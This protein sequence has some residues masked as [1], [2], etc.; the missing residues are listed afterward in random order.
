VSYW[1]PPGLMA[2]DP[3][4]RE[5]DW[6]IV[7]GRGIVPGDEDAWLVTQCFAPRGKDLASTA[8][9]MPT[10]KGLGALATYWDMIRVRAPE[11]PPRGGL[12]PDSVNEDGSVTIHY[13]DFSDESKVR[14]KRVTWAPKN[15]SAVIANRGGVPEEWDPKEKVWKQ[16]GADAEREFAKIAMGLAQALGMIASAVLSIV[17]GGATVAPL[18]SAAWG[19]AL[20]TI[21]GRG[22]PPSV[23]EVLSVVGAAGKVLGPGVWGVVSKNEDLQRLYKSGFIAKMRELPGN[24]SDKIAAAVVDVGGILP[25]FQ[26]GAMVPGFNV[27]AWASGEAK[28]LLAPAAANVSVPTKSGPI[29]LSDLPNDERRSAWDWAWKAF[30]EPDPA[31]RARIRRNFLWCAVDNSSAIHRGESTGLEAHAVTEVDGGLLSGGAYFDQYLASLLASTIEQIPRHELGTEA[32]KQLEE[33]RR[34]DPKAKTALYDLVGKLRDR[35]R[36]K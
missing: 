31:A 35:Y 24:Y 12:A 28:K 2:F 11:D 26:L 3:T 9:A 15:E 17:P 16:E 36:M 8:Y 19:F 18:F 27:G 25:R 7:E 32:A 30:V 10:V 13:W 1:N 14:R 5:L 22:K 29:P 21:A 33:R 20:K 23:D 6:K 34:A 4:V